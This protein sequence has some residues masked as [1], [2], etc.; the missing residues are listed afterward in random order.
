MSDV[1]RALHEWTNTLALHRFPY[2]EKT[3]PSDGVYILFQLSEESHGT[4]R[5]VRVGTHTGDNQLR[6]RLWQ[7]FLNENKDR[8]IFRKNI[9]RC[10][11]N[12]EKDPYLE[13][14]EW[15]LTTR[16]A[17]EKYR[18]QID[19]EKQRMLEKKITDYLQQNFSFV[20]LNVPEKEVRLD[21]ESKMLSTLAQCDECIPS[22]AWLGN[23][24]PQIKIRENGLWN[25]QG[26]DKSPLT[27]EELVQLTKTR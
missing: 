20:V 22:T 18:S 4:H 8:S 25:V 1:C 17:K 11:L 26:I 14:W 6:S 10:L 21:L 24:S 12:K 5:I 13:K 3:I 23:F 27:I 19:S 7:H 2:D 15:D 16:A 9:G